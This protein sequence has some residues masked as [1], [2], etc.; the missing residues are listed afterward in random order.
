MIGNGGDYIDSKRGSSDNGRE[1]QGDAKQTPTSNDISPTTK[2]VARRFNLK[3]DYS[4][5]IPAMI[6]TQEVLQNPGRYQG[7]GPSSTQNWTH[8]SDEEIDEDKEDNHN[9][10]QDTT[11]SVYDDTS[12]VIPSL[13]PMRPTPPLSQPKRRV[14]LS[15]QPQRSTLSRAPEKPDIISAAS[16]TIEVN[17]DDDPIVDFDDSDDDSD[18]MGRT[19]EENCEPIISTLSALTSPLRQQSL[20][21]SPYQSPSRRIIHQLMPNPPSYPSDITQQTASTSE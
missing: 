16:T 3:R 12:P 21:R 19:H 6:P 15:F 10:E 17:D 8:D 2:N 13:T 20:S 11:Y 18:L 9:Q 1:A 4:D 14:G 5:I 7:V